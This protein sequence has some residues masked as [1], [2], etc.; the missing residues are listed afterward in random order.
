[1]EEDDVVHLSEDLFQV[2]EDEEDLEDD[3]TR[4]RVPLKGCQLGGAR[5]GEEYSAD[6]A[7]ARSRAL[8]RYYSPWKEHQVSKLLFHAG[9]VLGQTPHRKSSHLCCLRIQ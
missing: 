7:K 6:F 2:R 8:L 5:A 1:M 4:N 3:D 9:G